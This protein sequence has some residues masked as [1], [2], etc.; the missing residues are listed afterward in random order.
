MLIGEP[1]MLRAEAAHFKQFEL[2]KGECGNQ[3]G[4]RGDF[5]KTAP[6]LGK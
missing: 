4:K 3:C 6:P 2:K 1:P 5:A